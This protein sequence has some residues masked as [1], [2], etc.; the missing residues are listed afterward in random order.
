MGAGVGLAVQ[1]CSA[2]DDLPRQPISGL[3]RLDGSPL[4]HGI[5]HYYPRGTGAHR[6]AVAGGAMIRT[7]RFSI[8]RELGL[9]PGKYT[10]AVF[11]A[12]TTQPKRENDSV[13]GN[14]TTSA[15]EMIP[16][17]YNSQSILEIEIKESHVIKEMTIDIESK[18]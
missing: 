1:G 10:V 18:R 8:S 11:S 9:I 4:A 15:P 3:V 17:K 7:G 13:P 2:D 6:P 12:I 16:A 14:A 5:V